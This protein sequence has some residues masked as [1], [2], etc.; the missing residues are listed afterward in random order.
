M[1]HKVQTVPKTNFT[2]EQVSLVNQLYCFLNDC[3]YC[4]GESITKEQILD[5]VLASHGWEWDEYQEKY[6]D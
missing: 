2:T 3:L 1:T 4:N 5:M 6:S